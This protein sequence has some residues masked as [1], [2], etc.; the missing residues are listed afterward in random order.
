MHV[1]VQSHFVYA[2]FNITPVYV[3]ATSFFS[4]Q[5]G[6][7]KLAIRQLE[8]LILSSST[9]TLS[10]SGASAL[11]Y[12][13]PL[14]R[15]HQCD[16]SNNSRSRLLGNN[17]GKSS[18]SRSEASGD[19]V[20]SPLSSQK[21]EQP[22]QQQGASSTRTS[23]SL[24]NQHKSYG[25]HLSTCFEPTANHNTSSQAPVQDAFKSS[26]RDAMAAPASSIIDANAEQHSHQSSLLSGIRSN[27]DLGTATTKT[28]DPEV[29]EDILEEEG[30]KSRG[31]RGG[32][33][34][35]SVAAFTK[36]PLP[37]FNRQ[38]NSN[39]TRIESSQATSK[40]APFK[41]TIS[42][43]DVDKGHS[44]RNRRGRRGRSLPTIRRTRA[45]LATGPNAHESNHRGSKTIVARPVSS[46]NSSGSSSSSTSSKRKSGPALRRSSTARMRSASLP[47]NRYSNNSNKNKPTIPPQ[48]L[49][50]AGTAPLEE[51]AAATACAATSI[52]SIMP[53][54]LETKQQ[55][56]A[57]PP[58]SFLPLL[59]VDSDNTFS[60]RMRNIIG[61][62]AAAPSRHRQFFSEDG[63]AISPLPPGSHASPPTL[64]ESSPN[65]TATWVEESTNLPTNGSAS[66]PP[67]PDILH[68]MNGPP[69][70][71]T[72][73]P[74]PSPRKDADL[75]AL[76]LELRSPPSPDDLP[77]FMVGGIEGNGGGAGGNGHMYGQWPMRPRQPAPPTPIASLHE[78]FDDAAVF[79]SPEQQLLLQ[80]LNSNDNGD[81]TPKRMR[82][83]GDNDGHGPGTPDSAPST[84]LS[85]DGHDDDF[86]VDEDNNL[87]VV[88]AAKNSLFT[89]SL[90]RNKPSNV[91]R[92]SSDETAGA[93]AESVSVIASG[94]PLMHHHSQEPEPNGLLPPSN[95]DIYSSGIKQTTNTSEVSTNSKDQG[96]KDT[97]LDGKNSLDDLKAV[98]R[99]GAL[100]PPPLLPA[101]QQQLPTPQVGATSLS[102]ALKLAQV[103]PARQAV[104]L[105]F[106]KA[107]VLVPAPM[108]FTTTTSADDT[109]V[110]A[111]ASDVGGGRN[112]EKGSSIFHKGVWR[113]FTPEELK[114]CAFVDM[115][116]ITEANANTALYCHLGLDLLDPQLTEASALARA[117]PGCAT[118]AKYYCCSSS[119]STTNGT[120]A[121][122]V[123]T[124]SA[125]SSSSRE[126]DVQQQ[127]RRRVRRFFGLGKNGDKR[128]SRAASD[129]ASNAPPATSSAPVAVHLLHVRMAD[130][131]QENCSSTR[132]ILDLRR[133]LLADTLQAV[134]ASFVASGLRV[135]RLPAHRLF[136]EACGAASDQGPRLW[137]EA[138]QLAF[139][140]LSLSERA[141]AAAR[142]VELCVVDDDDDNNDLLLC[143]ILKD[144][145]TVG[146]TLSDT[147][148]ATMAVTAAAND[149]A[150]SLSCTEEHAGTGTAY[151][152]V[153]HVAAA[154][155]VEIQQE[156]AV[157]TNH[158][159][160]YLHPEAM[161]EAVSSSSL[162]AASS[163]S[164]PPVKGTLHTENTAPVQEKAAELS[165][166]KEESEG[167]EEEDDEEAELPLPHQQWSFDGEEVLQAE[168]QKGELQR[169]ELHS[170][171]LVERTQSSYLNSNSQNEGRN[172]SWAA[173][174]ISSNTSA[175]AS[176]LHASIMS[177]FQEAASLERE[178]RH[179]SNPNM[180]PLSGEDNRS[181]AKPPSAN[182]VA[183]SHPNNGSVAGSAIYNESG[184]GEGSDREAMVEELVRVRGTLRRVLSSLKVSVRGS[185]SK[186][187]SSTNAPVSRKNRAKGHEN[188]PPSSSASTT[189]SAAS[190]ANPNNHHEEEKSLPSVKEQGE[191]RSSALDVSSPPHQTPLPPP[192][193]KEQHHQ[194]EDLRAE[195]E[196]LSKALAARDEELIRRKRLADL[197]NCLHDLNTKLPNYSSAN[198]RASWENEPETF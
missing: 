79:M 102:A 6:A 51:S 159:A 100:S 120:G 174:P 90:N 160:A 181:A 82:Q 132:N 77:S 130:P 146:F 198:H 71:S 95:L 137:W 149:E 121:E 31:R 13:E 143:N 88:E 110:A 128:G 18:G 64:W 43:E 122:G 40:H 113:R 163:I 91:P 101:P 94:A 103:S 189:A 23:S 140:Q 49:P 67:N 141:R 25:S 36:R 76:L 7:L 8:S 156:E 175:G 169:V 92:S 58:S 117:S 116:P 184:V 115:V 10:A 32:R 14:H 65:L 151:A 147:V 176:F 173:A 142:R 22:H 144:L 21:E 5:A 85:N 136:I 123:D 165:Q 119:D 96:A 56:A 162:F 104:A 4:I 112:G 75:N 195:N 41:K 126:G 20:R 114:K 166:V 124:A 178:I 135:L 57:R 148:R 63:E 180:R 168:L 12:D 86:N 186:S 171:L 59:S 2:H 24:S 193:Q 152:I 109:A 188:K 83:P 19:Q 108:H 45:P 194:Q 54:S 84:P 154:D 52:A 50:R 80:R 44:G 93:P 106:A 53:E 111:S 172:A 69:S 11:G 177:P 35:S 73:S 48:P 27:Q 47:S 70:H 26:S 105:D 72:W 153:N 197:Q 9:S 170:P 62:R 68:G 60:G 139:A 157:I 39:S 131:V 42:S 89:Q 179:I 125:S 28:F 167:E 196:R 87:R 66:H 134:L 29:E 183:S 155:R 187:S 99:E 133:E 185:V 55:S 37:F 15:L 97:F 33:W 34:A 17:D 127:P 182:S 190:V 46:S 1:F 161:L 129:S 150:I 3:A 107:V 16:N 81:T 74:V 158:Q 98:P 118:I 30:G 191:M 138:L 192:P 38:N 145:A 78:D 164:S 61:S